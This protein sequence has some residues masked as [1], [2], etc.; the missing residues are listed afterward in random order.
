MVSISVDSL[1][2]DL[3][4]PQA[5][6][7]GLYTAG[8]L[9]A[10]LVMVP[11]GCVLDRYDSRVLLTVAGLLLGIATHL[12]SQVSHPV[13]LHLGYVAIRALAKGIIPLIT[14]TLVVTWFVSMRGR[15]MIAACLAQASR[16]C[17]QFP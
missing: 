1:R 9:V 15:A 14:S 5:M 8:S 11:M 2:S 16:V 13:H 3:G 4:W 10:G 7:T 17:L 12:M 6:V